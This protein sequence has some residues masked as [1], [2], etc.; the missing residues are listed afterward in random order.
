MLLPL[1][2]STLVVARSCANQRTAGGRKG[3]TGSATLRRVALLASR[4]REPP[5]AMISC[6]HGMCCAYTEASRSSGVLHLERNCL[7]TGQRH[8]VVSGETRNFPIP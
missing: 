3:S 2:L 4:L 5:R 7:P 8:C 6:W 1:C